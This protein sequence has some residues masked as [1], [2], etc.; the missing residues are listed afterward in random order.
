LSDTDRVI[1]IG[2]GP[3]GAAAA[4][5]LVRRGIPVMLLESG[6]AR[7]GGLVVRASGRNVFRVGARPSPSNSFV[8]S[9]DSGTQW[10]NALTP[11]GLSNYW[12][13]AVPRFAPEDFVEGE[14]LHHRYRWP[15][16]YADLAPYYGQMERLL[17]VV[18]NS[19]DVPG[20]PGSQVVDQRVLPKDWRKVAARA[21]EFGQ[22]LTRM[23]MADGPRWMVGRTAFAFNSFNVIRGLLRSPRFEL[24]LGAHVLH[25]DWQGDERR[26]AS[27]TVFDRA[28]RSQQ[29]LPCAAVVVAAGPLASTKLLLDSACAD[30]PEGLGNIHGVL[31]RYLHDHSM[32]S[33]VLELD[34]PLSRLGHPAYLTR[35]TYV[36]SE[37]LRAASVTMLDH[38]LRAGLAS[39]GERVRSLLPSRSRRF[40]VV[41]FGT[42]VPTTS[43]H[44]ALDPVGKDE[45]GLPLLNIRLCF[46]EDVTRTSVC[47]RGQL[48]AILDSAGYHGR[49]DCPAPRPTPGASVHFG[50]T[51][52]MHSSP[53]H[54]MLDGRNRLHYVSNVVVADASAFTTGVEKNPTLTAMALSARASDHL[55]DDLRRGLGRE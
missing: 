13:G 43:N 28:T 1:V 30:F 47:A 31:G 21:A 40:G 37:P 22:G 32:D 34:R 33:C 55:V 17:R 16:S 7:P 42:I 4:M 9:G 45:F 25:L 29:R 38:R 10:H 3:S 14:R 23:P 24:R 54:G 50:G 36:K 20:L 49:F 44:V 12:T 46:D 2:S 11:G 41:T 26:V 48:L 52:R 51:V 5:T 19:L 8:A 15:L 39:V 53:E 6:A 18:G 27:V 35:P